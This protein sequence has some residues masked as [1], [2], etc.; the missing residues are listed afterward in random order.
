MS[1]QKKKRNK[2]YTG[3]DAS[4]DRPIITRIAA[5][6]RSKIGQWWFDH[7]RIA[8]PVL[9]ASGI[10]VFVTILIVQIVQVASGS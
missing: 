10:V 8:K 7:K 6:N 2:A 9:I 3:I 5:V 1:K 4:I